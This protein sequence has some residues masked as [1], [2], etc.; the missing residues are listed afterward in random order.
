MVLAVVPVKVPLTPAALGVVTGVGVDAGVDTG[1]GL[2]VFLGVGLGVFL[3]VVV[4]PLAGFLVLEGAGV[5]VDAGVDGVDGGVAAGVVTGVVL[6]PPESELPE[7]S[8]NPAVVPNCGGV[9]E[10]TAPRPVTVPPAIK[11]KRLVSIGFSFNQQSEI[12]ILHCGSDRGEYRR[13]GR[14]CAQ[15]RPTLMGHKYKHQHRQ[16]LEQTW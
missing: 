1:V 4:P 13:R 5:G 2:R 3:G 10:S 16:K 15:F 9:I 7:P 14:P 8:A 6:A 12:R 11:K